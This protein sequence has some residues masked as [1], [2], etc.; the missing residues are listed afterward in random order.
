MNY[1]YKSTDSSSKYQYYKSFPRACLFMELIAL[2]VGIVGL[3][4]GVQTYSDI[5]KNH[6]K[7]DEVSANEAKFQQGTFGELSSGMYFPE[8]VRVSPSPPIFTV[9]GKGRMKTLQVG[10]ITY[11][12][13]G[14]NG[15]ILVVKNNTLV[16]VTKKTRLII[17][18]WCQK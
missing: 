16:P 5:D 11:P 9:E 8:T 12:T 17:R 4:I 1:H 13:G 15:Q 10:S 18:I 2:L 14:E 7:L 6:V 3:V